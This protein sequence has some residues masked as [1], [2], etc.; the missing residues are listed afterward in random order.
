[1]VVVIWR[2]PDRK[3][4]ALLVVSA[5]AVWSRRDAESGRLS[6]AASSRIR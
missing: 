5:V 4:V 2:L 6:G 1:M 3:P